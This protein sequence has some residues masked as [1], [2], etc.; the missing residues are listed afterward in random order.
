MKENACIFGCLFSYWPVSGRSLGDEE[1]E[2]RREWKGK[3]RGRCKK[4]PD[5]ICTVTERNDRHG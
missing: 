1:H 5:N 4:M 2:R 3:K